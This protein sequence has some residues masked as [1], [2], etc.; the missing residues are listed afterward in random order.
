MNA[1]TVVVVGFSLFASVA[2]LMAAG[3]LFEN[4]AADKIVV[5]QSPIS[6]DLN[7]YT[8]PGVKWQGFGKITEYDKRSIYSFDTESIDPV[9]KQPIGG[10]DIRF[11]DGGH[12]RIL[13][14]IQYDMPMDAKHLTEIH[15][16]YGSQ[17][18]VQKQLIETITNKSIYLVGPLMTS[19]ESYAEK[20]NDMI[21]YVTDQIQ[22]GVYKTYQK[23]SWV[24][25]DLTGVSKEVTT[26]EIAMRNG[27]PERQ[28]DAVLTEFGIK[29]FNF[30]IKQMPYDQ[31]VEN[32]I[33]Q[34]Q[35]I[36]MDVQTAIA[37]AKKAEQEK[38]TVEAQGA[39][40]AARTK[41]EQEAIKA[42]EVTK[43]EQEKQVATTLA[44]KTRDVAKLEKDAAE[45]TKQKDILLGQGESERKRLIIEA[46]GALQAKLDAFVKTQETWAGAF[47]NYRGNVTPTIM[48][49][50]GGNAS[51][52]SNAAVDF[53]QI[54]GI[55]AAKDLA[56]D[57]DVAAG[58]NKVK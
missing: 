20:R 3:N 45:F 50:A 1:K 35:A 52:T 6:G 32:Q 57:M 44:E 46:D 31:T 34:Q 19:K 4:V 39:A 16:R 5:I 23:K 17:L 28:E 26:A 14:S 37:N 38:L 10:I 2:T 27:I 7:W 47:A 12:G 8:T 15:T 48:S 54:M 22:N 33:K 53:M 18:A 41:W 30:T 24:K 9:T 36:A 40:N 11:N 21:H 43:A 25:D 13:G 29:A 58:R 51:G 55:K 42:K 56:L 49:G